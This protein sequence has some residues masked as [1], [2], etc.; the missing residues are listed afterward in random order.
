MARVALDDPT[1]IPPPGPAEIAEAVIGLCNMAPVTPEPTPQLIST[2]NADA[3]VEVVAGGLL[4]FAEKRNND[5]SLKL[6]PWRGYALRLAEGLHNW[7]PL[8]DQDYDITKPDKFNKTVVPQLLKDFVP[9][10]TLK[11]LFPM[12]KIDAKGNPDPAVKVDVQ[13][14]DKRLTELRS[15]KDR[16][17]ILFAGL[18]EKTI[19]FERRK[20]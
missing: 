2:Y 17:T 20:D 7:Q 5:K 19:V 1:L 16:N 6:L 12:Q 14:L 13:W 9:D 11:I 15:K 18:K 8:F 4:A 10:V 3:A